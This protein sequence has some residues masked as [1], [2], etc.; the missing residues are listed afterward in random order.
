MELDI[1]L[2]LRMFSIVENIHNLKFDILKY[3][4]Y[5]KP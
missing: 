2:N 1:F 4:S 5:L 3:S